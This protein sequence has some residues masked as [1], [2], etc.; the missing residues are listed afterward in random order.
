MCTEGKVIFDIVNGFE[1]KPMV[2]KDLSEGLKNVEIAVFT[3]S[4]IQNRFEGTVDFYRGWQDYKHGF[5]NIGGEFWLGL[6]KLHLLTNYKVNE[7]FIELQDFTLEKSHAQYSAFAVGSE[8]EGYPISVLGKYEGT[9]GDSLVYHAGMRFSAHDMDHDGWEDGNCAHSHKGAWWYNGCDTSNLN[10]QYLNG[11]VPENYEYQGMYWY[12]WRG[13]SYSLMK[14]R[15][16]VRPRS[17]VYTVTE[18]SGRTK[19]GDK[20]VDKEQ[21]KGALNLQQTPQEDPHKSQHAE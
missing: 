9:A 3:I 20:H 5:G 2:A 8:I 14:S 19:L 18:S 7:L 21:H 6:E 10:G 16:S 11:E 12:D 1:E 13:P 4:V 17:Q 15:I